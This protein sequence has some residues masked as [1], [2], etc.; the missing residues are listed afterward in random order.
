[1]F[2]KPSMFRKGEVLLD[3]GEV[4]HVFRL[5]KT[6]LVVMRQQGLDGVD[7]PIGL[8]GRGF[9]TGQMGLYGLPSMIRFEASGSVGVCE[10]E[11]VA[12]RRL[13]VL[14]EQ[15]ARAVVAFHVKAT[16]ALVAWSQ[17]MRERSLHRR[18]AMALMLMAKDHGGARMSLPGQRLLAELLAVTRESV[19]R[20]L[21]D[22]CA[23]RLVDRVDRSVVVV[24]QVAM[25]KWFSSKE[26][27]TC[28]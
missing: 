6:G 11:H 23:W 25:S 9:M 18:L 7:R 28:L 10:V 14:D 12:L 24:D 13:G 19:G 2:M 3:A 15:G 21:D 8:V 5:I 4:S 26:A 1:M 22:L 16:K 17:L 27:P 20:A